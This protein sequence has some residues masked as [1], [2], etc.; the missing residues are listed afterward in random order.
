MR[1]RISRRVLVLK[2][3]VAIGIVVARFLPAEHAVVAEL[4]SNLLW[5][6]A[7]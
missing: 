7:F 1:I 4:A 6:V 5:L 3:V 2:G